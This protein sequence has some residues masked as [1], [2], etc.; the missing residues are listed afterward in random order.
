MK[1][2]EID[3]AKQRFEDFLKINKMRK[4]EE[5][6]QILECIYLQPSLFEVAEL[7]EKMQAQFR[8]SLA[9]IYSTIEL[10]LQCNLI[11]RHTFDLQKVKYE[12]APFGSDNYYRVCLQCGYFKAF[13]DLKLNKSISKRNSLVFT[14]LH[15]SL[16]IYGICKEC[17]KKNEKIK[18]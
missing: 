6:F 15:N 7:H 3:S 13:S 11:I 9:T 12:K 10:L 5:R 2:E 8:V 18:R 16:Y 1:T 4:T 17:E 14:P